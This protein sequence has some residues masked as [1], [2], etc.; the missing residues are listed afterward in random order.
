M[1]FE[2]G[3]EDS[4]PQP[5]IAARRHPGMDTAHG[6]AHCFHMGFYSGMGRYSKDSQEI[7]YVLVCDECGEEVREISAEPYAP[8]PAL[9]AA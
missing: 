8:N 7:R 1:L 5:R 4:L 2:V 9:E 6:Q 3:I